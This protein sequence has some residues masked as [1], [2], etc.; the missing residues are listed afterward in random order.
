MGKAEEKRSKN[1]TEYL[2]Y[3][4]KSEDLIRTFE[5]DLNK[6]TD[7]L[8]S[9]IPI[10]TQEKK[11]L[12][13]WYASLIESM[14]SENIIESG[15]IEEVKILLTELNT[16]HNA[17]IK[18]DNDYNIIV[19]K[20]APFI[21][22]QIEKSNNKLNNPIQVCLNAIYGF[23]LLKVDEKEPT[24]EQQTMLNAFGDLLSYLSHKYKEQEAS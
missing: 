5:Y 10:S 15:H 21:Q 23:L 17:L 7:Y 12:I 13:L 18:D 16:L 19:S 11:E 14:Q 2:I 9:Q 22:S 6:I 3:M 24:A 8:I 1:I 4:F 20:A